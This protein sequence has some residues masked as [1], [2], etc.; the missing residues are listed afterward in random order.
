MEVEKEFTID[1]LQMKDEIQEKIS[2]A[3]GG[4]FT[5]EKY[6]TLHKKMIKQGKSRLYKTVEEYE[7]RTKEADHLSAV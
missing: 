5:L 4:N 1:A 7:I 3:L 6:R 2:T